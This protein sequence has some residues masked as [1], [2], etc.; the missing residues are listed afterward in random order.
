MCGFD[1]DH[2]ELPLAEL[3]IEAESWEEFCDIASLDDQREAINYLCQRGFQLAE[4]TD[5]EWPL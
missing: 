4:L 1:Y 3:L 2:V 5:D